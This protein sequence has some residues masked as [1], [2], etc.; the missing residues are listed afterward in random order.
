MPSIH[1]AMTYL[2][3]T[4]SNNQRACSKTN[5][6]VRIAA[7]WEFPSVS[8]VRG[9]WLGT[10]FHSIPTYLPNLL[11]A[12]IS[13]QTQQPQISWL[14]KNHLKKCDTFS[15]LNWSTHPFSYFSFTLH[16]GHLQ[17]KWD[18]IWDHIYIYIPVYI[19]YIYS[20]TVTELVSYF[21]YIYIY[22]YIHHIFCLLFSW[23]VN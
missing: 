15:I 5:S 19:L 11:H 7:W 8:W 21:K 10:Y 12:R 2:A 4:I 20:H 14:I 16:L 1:Q 17:R 23:C 9:Q 22:I 3:S 13:A 6:I 18:Q